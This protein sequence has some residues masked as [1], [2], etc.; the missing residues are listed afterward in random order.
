[1]DWTQEIILISG[2]SSGLGEALSIAAGSRMATV[3]LL[4]R[5]EERLR[6]VA[7]RVKDSGGTAFCLRYDLH[8][9][10]GIEEL[11]QS[12]KA[13]VPACPTILINNAGYNAAGFVHNTPAAVYRENFTVNLFSPI[14]LMQAVIPDMLRGKRGAIVNILGAANYHSFPG[15]SSYCASKSALMAVH[16]SLQ[17]ELSGWPIKTLS[18]NPGSF[19]SNYGANRKVDGRLGT[20]QFGQHA[21]RDPGPIAEAILRALETGATTLDLSTGMDR[22]G[23]H[24]AYWM[25]GLLDRLLVSRNQKLLANRKAGMR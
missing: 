11:Y 9:L 1:M 20:Y 2:A 18:V 8:D 12:I 6:S 13:A 3:V 21:G 14:A 22:L 23:R 5:N 10:E 7:K 16:E 25:P 24:L 17:T 19:R 4:G 15:A